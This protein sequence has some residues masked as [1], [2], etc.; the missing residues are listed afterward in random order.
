MGLCKN[1]GFKVKNG[2]WFATHNLHYLCATPKDIRILK[3]KGQKRFEEGQ[4]NLKSGMG[5][6]FGTKYNGFCL[7]I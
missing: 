1:C 3:E 4:N 7:E 2:E 6:H 5:S